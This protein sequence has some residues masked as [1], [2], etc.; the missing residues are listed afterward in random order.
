MRREDACWFRKRNYLHFD[1]PIG[2]AKAEQLVTNPQKVSQHSFY[3][4]I[5][6]SID[7]VKISKDK[8]TKNIQ[9]KPKKRPISYP[10]HKDGHIYS[11]YSK[12][13]AQRY[14]EEIKKAQISESVLAFRQ[15]GKSNIDFAKE[16]FDT[17]KRMGDCSVVA[18]DITA[19]FDTLDHKILKEKWSKTLGINSLPEDHYS[20]YKSITKFSIVSK[21]RLY[22]EL[23]ISKNNP[24]KNRHR[25]CSP[26]EF[27]EKVRKKVLV[28]TNKTGKGIPQGTPISALLSNIY[29]IDFDTLMQEAVSE[30]GGKYFRYCDDMLF[31]T[32]VQCR[33]EVA[34]FVQ[35]EINKLEL[36]IQPTK[37]ERRTFITT[38]TGQQSDKPLQYLGFT[39]DGE[40]ILIRSSSLSRYSR[41]VKG[42][43]KLAKSTMKKRNKERI[44]K[45]MP[46]ESIYKKKLYER[47]SH[48]GK[49]N[50]ITYGHRAASK[51]NSIHIRRQL[52][53]LWKRLQ[54][55][56]EKKEKQRP[57]S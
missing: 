37:T 49:T 23:G 43:V 25:L 21:E 14:E 41:K 42:G 11:Y 17:I 3:P 36:S 9:K 44:D 18:L 28:K 24:K 54:E 19:F 38:P 51:M 48:L 8:A 13:I 57:K 5:S 10:S 56:I 15:L 1:S 16:A 31:I 45:G 6:Y 30:Q 46:E 55:E 7:S 53:P 33:D 26:S 29:M 2:F 39:F 35:S 20:I 32:P 27:R 22:E 12:I 34:G 4:L 52:K 50:F 47:Y 40:R